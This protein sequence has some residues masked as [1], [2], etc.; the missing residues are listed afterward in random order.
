[1]KGSDGLFNWTV[2]CTSIDGTELILIPMGASQQASPIVYD[3]MSQI[4]N[5]DEDPWYH[6][7]DLIQK[8]WLWLWL[9]LWLL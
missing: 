2:I 9:W 6:I 3:Q 1:M 5:I 8:C 7:L 4:L